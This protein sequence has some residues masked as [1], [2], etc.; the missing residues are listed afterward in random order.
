MKEEAY[1]SRGRCVK[2]EASHLYAVFLG[3]DL[4][5][6]GDQALLRDGEGALAVLQDGAPCLNSCQDGT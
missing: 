3:H 1:V 2:E 4:L 5:G 6:E